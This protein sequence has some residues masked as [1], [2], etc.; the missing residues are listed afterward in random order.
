VQKGLHAAQH[1]H[2]TFAA[3]QETKLRHFHMLLEGMVNA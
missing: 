3:Y 2:V 1:G